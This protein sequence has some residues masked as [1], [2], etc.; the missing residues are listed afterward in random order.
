MKKVYAQ[1]IEISKDLI[2]EANEVAGGPVNVVK[3]TGLNFCSI[4]R[5]HEQNKCLSFQ[6][7]LAIMHVIGRD[8][9]ME[10][11]DKH[12]EFKPKTV[13]DIAK[14]R[15]IKKYLTSR[16]HRVIASTISKE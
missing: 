10:I 4:W 13:G 12:L 5:I 16:L 1:T 15:K 9:F 7:A 3:M 8:R 14:K 6:A 2:T 11:V